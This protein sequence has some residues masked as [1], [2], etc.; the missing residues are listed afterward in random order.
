MNQDIFNHFQN[1]IETTMVVGD[2]CSDS[3]ANASEIITTA[4]LNGHSVFSC[5]E[6]SG[7]LMAQLLT[8]HLSLGFEIERPAFPALNMNKMCAEITTQ[9]RFAN[10]IETH[11]RSSDV[12]VVISAGD[13]SPSMVHAVESAIE[14]GMVVVLLSAVNDDRLSASIGYNDVNISAGQFSGQLVTQAQFQTVQ[15]LGALVENKIFGGS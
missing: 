1:V 12:L 15:C 5:G 14:K 4:L 7:S 10:V 3:I 6:K 9:N 2:I 11:A 13:N 8:D